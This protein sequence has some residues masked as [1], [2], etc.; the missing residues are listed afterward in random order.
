MQEE[1]IYTSHLKPCTDD[2]AEQGIP[3]RPGRPPGT[4]EVTTLVTR[5][6]GGL[7]AAKQVSFKD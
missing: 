1:I 4:S 2:T 6:C 3:R 5:C 7:P